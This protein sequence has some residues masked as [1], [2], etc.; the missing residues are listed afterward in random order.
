MAAVTRAADAALDL[1]S[2]LADPGSRLGAVAIDALLPA[3]PQLVLVPLGIFVES[4]SMIRAST[5]LGWAAVAV[6]FLVDLVLLHRYGQTIG[7]RVMGLRIVRAN[8]E[9][10]SLGRLFW[11]RTMLP[12]AIGVIPILGWLFSLVDTLTIF[13]V[14][15]RTIHDRM[16]D[17]VVIDLRAPLGAPEKLE[18]VFT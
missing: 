2:P 5:W 4:A 15:R 11:L 13:S 10:A 16:A 3:A 1:R 18:E 14:D 17:T 7:K 8:G 12:G 6:F 9:K